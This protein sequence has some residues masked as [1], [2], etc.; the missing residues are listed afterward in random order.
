VDVSNTGSD[1]L[2][3]SSVSVSHPDYSVDVSSFSLAPEEARSIFVTFAPTSSATISADLTIQSDDLDEPTVV[4]ALSGEGVAP[5]VITVSPASLGEDLLSGEVS[6]QTVTIANEG[7]ANLEWSL[8]ADFDVPAANLAAPAAAP[9]DEDERQ[10]SRGNASVRSAWLTFDPAAGSVPGNASTDVAVTFDATGRP[11]GDYHADL[12]VA[13]NDPIMPEV[14]VPVAL[15]VTGTPDVEVTPLA[16]DFGITFIGASPALVVSVSNVGSDLLTVMSVAADH[17]DYSVDPVSFVVAAGDTR[18]VVVTFAPTTPGPVSADLS[19]ES[20]DPDEPIVVV[21][22][23]GEGAEPPIIAVSP[24]SLAEQLAAG[25]ISTQPL[26]ITNE[27]V[28]DLDWV[29]FAGVSDLEGVRILWD[30]SHGQIH[31]GPWSTMVES[32]TLRGAE[33]VASIQRIEPSWLAAFDVLWAVDSNGGWT[34]EQ[35]DAVAD[36]VQAGGVLLLEGDDTR[37]VPDFNLLLST[38]GAGIA[39]SPVDG[40]GGPTT[41]ILPHQTT[42]GVSAVQLGVGVLAH[43]SSVGTPAQRLVNDAQD[44]PV[45]AGSEVGSGRIVAMSDEILSNTVIDFADNQR[46]GNQVFGWL[47]GAPAWI[48]VGPSGGQVPS[49]GSADVT[50]TFD[51]TML[52]AGSYLAEVRVASNDPITP[53]VLVPAT[54]LVTESLAET[55]VVDLGGEALFPTIFALH[56]STP[57]PFRTSATIHFDLPAESPVDLRV[58]EVS[59]RLVRVLATGGLPRGRHAV[60]WNGLDARGQRAAP[61][62]YF[63]RLEAGEFIKT[64][65]L[66]R[67]R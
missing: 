35:A 20:D 9:M 36:W 46:F 59:G 29:A 41:N 10:L 31:P 45:V 38:L 64:R 43:L 52:S 5:P 56:Q 49:G 2:T 33:V 18:E 51:A 53:E 55:A 65:R 58:F 42:V 15:H 57:N 4:V 13:S 19:I 11:G 61:G 66:V 44:V 60:N 37:A 8:S 26:T 14:I 48:S 17:S 22:L 30:Q 63:Y 40:T 3:V 25:A 67:I 16:L 21:S 12:V 50:V 39:Y 6:T 24:D 7:E 47:I 32:L 28:A 34:Q 27:G 23:T 62:V 54:L 1:V